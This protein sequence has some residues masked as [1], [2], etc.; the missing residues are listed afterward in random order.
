MGKTRTR[1]GRNSEKLEKERTS[2]M[3]DASIVNIT[4][5]SDSVAADIEE[6]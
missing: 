2:S 1:G 6:I 4:Q 3:N 5:T